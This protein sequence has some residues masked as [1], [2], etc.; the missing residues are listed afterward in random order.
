MPE[1]PGDGVP[2]VSEVPDEQAPDADLRAARNEIRA[3][4][5]TLRE[6]LAADDALVAGQRPAGEDGQ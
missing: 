1:V 4:G 6:A 2:E 5:A 3:V